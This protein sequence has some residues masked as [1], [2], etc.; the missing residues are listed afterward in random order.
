MFRRSCSRA[1]IDSIDVGI[2]PGNQTPR[3]LATVRAI[4]S[5]AGKRFERTVD[6]QVSSVVGWSDTHWRTYP[7]RIGRRLLSAC[8]VPDL[9]LFPSHYGCRTVNFFAGL[10]LVPLHLAT[11]LL[12]F[13]AEWGLVRD[14]SQ[15]ARPL[16][17]MSER[18]K[19]FGSTAG[20]MHVEVRGVRKGDKGSA[21]SSTASSVSTFFLCA[22]NGIGNPKLE[23]TPGAI[24]GPEIPV[25][26]TVVIVS[27]L[28]REGVSAL[29]GVGA[30][31]CVSL[32]TVDEAMA[33]MEGMRVW[34]ETH[35][36][37]VP[38]G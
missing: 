17:W 18:L 31:P 16:A 21:T 23:N 6:G 14:V 4:L 26:P 24:A 30:R 15:Y 9:E 3:G 8:D 5:Y 36:D 29:G 32:I 33:S 27:K 7:E 38:R 34:T 28:A 25:T 12:R 13:P 19:V 22:D 35:D 2:N 1:A 10:E 20:A 37:G 11:T